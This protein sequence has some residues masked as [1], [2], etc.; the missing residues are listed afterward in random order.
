MF[1]K[2]GYVVVE[3]DKVDEGKLL[4][5]ITDAGADDMAE[6]GSNWE[7]F[8]SP[9][10][11][12][13]VVERLKAAHVAPAA[14]EVSMIPQSFVKLSGKEAHQIMR[15]LEELVDHVDVQNVYRNFEYV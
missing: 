13:Q 3:K 11:L 6:D 2:K 5:L 10:K 4:D 14:A 12:H 8:S 9:D 1:H 15:L 7:I